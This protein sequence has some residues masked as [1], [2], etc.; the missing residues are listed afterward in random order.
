[1]L[2]V[3][4]L[5]DGVRSLQDHFSGEELIY[6]GSRHEKKQ[7]GCD[8]I[9]LFKPVYFNVLDRSRIAFYRELFAMDCNVDLVGGIS[10][11]RE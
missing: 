2:Y 5:A 10:S 3:I 7:Q 4:P 11:S 1:M 6:A 8:V 9:Q